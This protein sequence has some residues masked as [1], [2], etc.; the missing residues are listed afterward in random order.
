MMAIIRPTEEIGI[1]QKRFLWAG[2]S[3][4]TGGKCK[5]NWAR[6][7]LPKRCVVG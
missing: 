4:T 7:T 6:T 1:I 3:A 5:V 2:D